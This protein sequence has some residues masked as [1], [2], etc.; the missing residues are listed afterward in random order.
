MPTAFALSLSSSLNFFLNRSVA[1]KIPIGGTATN[2]RKIPLGQNTPSFI[3]ANVNIDTVF[4]TGPPKSISAT[5]PINIANPIAFVVDKP[6]IN[7]SNPFTI[8]AIGYPI[9]K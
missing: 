3:K 1:K 6:V 9:T 5:A 7:F 2:T 4:V 8:I